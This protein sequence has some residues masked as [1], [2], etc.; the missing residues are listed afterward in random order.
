MPVQRKHNNPSDWRN[1]IPGTIVYRVER[2]AELFLRVFLFICIPKKGK[3]TTHTCVESFAPILVTHA[4][5]HARTNNRPKSHD[6]TTKTRTGNFATPFSLAIFQRNNRPT[7]NPLPQRS[8]GDPVLVGAPNCP[9]VGRL[10]CSPPP[11][12]QTGKQREKERTVRE[13]RVIALE[14]RVKV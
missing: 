10:V 5:T 8:G 6:G 3:R 13:Q 4:R 7:T 1:F 12:K 14:R 9:T 11:G 2:F